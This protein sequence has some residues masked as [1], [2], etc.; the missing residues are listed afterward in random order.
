MVTLSSRSVIQWVYWCSNQPLWKWEAGAEAFLCFFPFPMCSRTAP[1]TH[2]HTST[3]SLPVDLATDWFLWVWR[4][5]STLKK[6]K[7]KPRY[8]STKTK[9]SLLVIRLVC[10]M[11]ASWFEIIGNGRK[12]KYCLTLFL[13]LQPPSPPE[14]AACGCVRV[15][16]LLRTQFVLAA[17]WHCTSPPL[18]LVGRV[19]G[20]WAFCYGS[21]ASLASLLSG[22]L[23]HFHH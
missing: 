7:N 1:P 11:N 5:H 15:L 20:W 2:T 4:H 10:V 21:S 13:H 8:V 12:A 14:I 18:T 16:G 23:S 19:W 17:E 9:H 6:L 3:P 22:V